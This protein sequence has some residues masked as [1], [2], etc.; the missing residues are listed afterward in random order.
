MS[1]VYQES[2]IGDDGE[3]ER[4]I[5]RAAAKAMANESWGGGRGEGGGDRGGL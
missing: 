4:I 1:F 5:S 3:G 2:D